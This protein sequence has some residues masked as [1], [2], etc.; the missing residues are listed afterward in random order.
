LALSFRL[1]PSVTVYNP[2]ESH[3]TTSTLK[4]ERACFSETLASTNQ[5]TQCLNPKEHHHNH[6]HHENL[7]SSKGKT[8]PMLKNHSMKMHKGI[9]IRYHTFLTSTTD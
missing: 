8:V 4:M 1:P 9:K 6:H 5:S 2:S 3:L 7:K